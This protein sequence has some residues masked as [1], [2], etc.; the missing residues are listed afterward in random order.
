MNFGTVTDADRINKQ[1]SDLIDRH[2]KNSN[3]I[4]EGDELKELGMSR[5]ADQNGDQA[6]TKNE[7]VAFYTPKPPSS[8]S[9]QSASSSASAAES[10]PSTSSKTVENPN[11]GDVRKLVNKTRK[12]YRFKL[13]KE[14][15][16]TWRFASRDANGDGQVAMSEYS[17]SWSD[18]TAAEFQR[19]DRDND[20][21]ITPEEVR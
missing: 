6:I 17:R 20:G 19:Y 15:I 4:L 12:S 11:G 2:D 8:T 10:R 1:A 18:R 7:L 5:G 21:M 13:A 16:K 14:R 9:T 3:H